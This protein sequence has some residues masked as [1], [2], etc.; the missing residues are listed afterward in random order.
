MGEE[1]EMVYGRGRE[2]RISYVGDQVV[3]YICVFVLLSSDEVETGD[4]GWK[5]GKGHSPKNKGEE[6][7]FTQS[8]RI[9]PLVDTFV[10]LFFNLLNSQD[11]LS[12]L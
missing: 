2:V 4:A 6:G 5:E 9:V 10:F 12:F 7:L 1:N 11:D 3:K 8:H